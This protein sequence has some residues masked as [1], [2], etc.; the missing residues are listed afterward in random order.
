MQ[1][2]G[3][4]G[5]SF[6]PVHKGHLRIAKSFLKSGLIE[7]LLVIPAP[8]PPHKDDIRVGFKHRYEMLKLAFQDWS[9]VEVS[10]LEEKLPAPSYSIQTIEYLQLEHPNTLFYLC[11]GEDSLIHFH[12]WFRYKDIV[13][14][15]TLLVAER[16]HFDSSIIDKELLEKT[17]FVDH[18]PINLSSTEIRKS[19][20]NQ[21]GTKSIPESVLEY[22]HIHKLYV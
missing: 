10:D 6:D 11:L 22:M 8:A 15:V 13:E 14:R 5:G 18:K 17:I 9:G 16:P 4:L 3:I 2:V 20:D 12:T 7:K 21:N 1:R 19:T